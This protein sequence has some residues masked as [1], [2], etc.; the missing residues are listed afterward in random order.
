MTSN[1]LKYYI[2]FLL[3]IFVDYKSSALDII[4]G[5]VY[6]EDFGRRSP[7]AEAKIVI[8]GSTIGT[9]SGKD[10]NF[11]IQGDNLPKSGS[12]IVSKFNFI[13]IY[14]D[15]NIATYKELNIRLIPSY[16]YF[17]TPPLTGTELD[18]DPVKFT[19]TVRDSL[20]NRTVEGVIVR[21]SETPY[22]CIT[23][24]DGKF[25]IQIT[26]DEVVVSPRNSFTLLFDK[27]GFEVKATSYD[28]KNIINELKKN[29]NVFN[30]GNISLEKYI[31]T[32]EL[33]D[34]IT[35]KDSLV[36]QIDQY[37]EKIKS[38]TN[39][40]ASPQTLTV[41]SGPDKQRLNHLICRYEKDS[42]RVNDILLKYDTNYSNYNE[43]ISRLIFLN[44]LSVSKLFS[45]DSQTKEN[46][47]EIDQVKKDNEDDIV[48]LTT[49][50]DDNIIAFNKNV[51]ILN[52]SYINRAKQQDAN[53]LQIFFTFPITTL[54]KYPDF[55][56]TK[57]NG[58]IGASSNFNWNALKKAGIYF[59][60][61]YTN[62]SF[63]GDSTFYSETGKNINN[64]MKNKSPD[65][66]A[67]AI[68]LRPPVD[69]IRNLKIDPGIGV[70]Y[71]Y[72]FKKLI[73]SNV[74]DSTPNNSPQLLVQLTLQY[75][76]FNPKD[77]FYRVDTARIK[78]G[79]DNKAKDI[80][81]KT[82]W[83]IMQNVGQSMYLYLN[84]SDR[85][86]FDDKEFQYGLTYLG[87]G[88][89]WDIATYWKAQKDIKK[90]RDR[91]II[92]KNSD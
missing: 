85:L 78:T 87:I 20:N 17:I 63:H 18:S 26:K 73:V 89:K 46:K 59:S 91:F 77:N 1:L 86:V 32:S 14:L 21:L 10:G 38:D 54:G 7:I 15:F 23:D 9:Y 50:L 58:Q 30:C 33:N 70:A 5:S 11:I 37:L 49:K 84:V 56:S 90:E 13:P 8:I 24:K 75:K 29:N 82:A 31:A 34:L 44:S 92:S 61:S 68:N 71:G 81:P 88:L 43:I 41:I 55:I 3:L 72:N 69:F 62:L 53:W 64:A 6:S 2:I 39:K 83:K 51:E 47:E 40:L 52:D 66:L 4:K 22:S 25:I 36:K 48:N 76:L 12:L 45:V 27:P 67:L 28:K 65:Y 57:P 19:G 35:W 80:K 60:I 74:N 79:K 16:I 42:A